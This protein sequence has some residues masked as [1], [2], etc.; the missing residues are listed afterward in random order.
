M[1]SLV[2]LT[3]SP[4]V[5]VGIDRHARDGPVAQPPE[6]A[7]AV[8]LRVRG[9]VAVEPG[10][11][12]GDRLVV[13]G[14]RA[15]PRRGPLEH[16]QLPDVGGD[17][18][19]ELHR[20]G[21]GADHRDPA[22]GEVDRLVPPRRVEG[23]ALEGAEAGDRRGEVGPVELADRAHHRVEHR[24]LLAAVARPDGDGPAEV[25]VRPDRGHD[26]GPEPDPFAQPER[27]RAAAEVLL[28][29]RLRRVVERPVV[30]LRERVAVGVVRVVDATA[31]VAV[32][33]PGAADVVVLLEDDVLHP[34]LL[35]AV[36][37]EQPGHAARR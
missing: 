34:G 18:R 12:R 14:R 17:L 16:E 23:R 33:V 1:S 9:Q 35:Q 7:E 37:R 5:P 11:R 19:D 20:A 30:A 29:D 28:E 24:H 32:L 22:P 10:H 6:E 25:V 2:A 21:T 8:P 31:R 26:L 36:G 27:V 13:V 4:P 3:D 15:H